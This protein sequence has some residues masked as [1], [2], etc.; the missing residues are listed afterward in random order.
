MERFGRMAEQ[1]RAARFRSAR[2]HLIERRRR[3]LKPRAPAPW[4]LARW[5]YAEY[6]RF[7]LS[8]PFPRS[9]QDA[10][11]LDRAHYYTGRKCRRGHYSPRY[12]LNGRCAECAGDRRFIVTFAPRPST[13]RAPEQKR[14]AYVAA[15]IS[16]LTR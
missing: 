13:E 9:R 11:A 6:A 10:T 5:A 2:R 15:T 16:R 12:T 1:K 4:L 14:T 7:G 3:K 8:Q